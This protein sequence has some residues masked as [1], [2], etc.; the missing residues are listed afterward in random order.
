MPKVQYAEV[1][2]SAGVLHKPQS[3]CFCAVVVYIIQLHMMHRP[4]LNGVVNSVCSLCLF[5]AYVLINLFCCE[6][7][8]HPVDIPM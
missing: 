1:R 4:Y 8:Q 3:V 5:A 6:F 7:V 2:W